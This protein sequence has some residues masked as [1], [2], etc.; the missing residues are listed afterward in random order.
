[1][2]RNCCERGF[3]SA[4]TESEEI[5][6][7]MRQGLVMGLETS[8]LAE[9]YETRVSAKHVASGPIVQAPDAWT[10]SDGPVRTD[11]VTSKIK[12]ERDV[13]APDRLRLCR[14][15]SPAAQSVSLPTV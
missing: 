3:R 5:A 9:S 11:A 13:M 2:D 12:R 15:H 7:A 1:M 8:R 14:P 4:P 10:G 6:P